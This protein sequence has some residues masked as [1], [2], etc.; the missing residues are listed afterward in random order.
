MVLTNPDNNT[1]LHRQVH[2]SLFF[3]NAMNFNQVRTYLSSTYSRF[4]FYQFPIFNFSNLNSFK[5]CCKKI[6]YFYKKI[7]CIYSSFSPFKIMH[8]VVIQVGEKNLKIQYDLDYKALKLIW[9]PT[10]I[11]QRHFGKVFILELLRCD[12]I[13]R[14][15]AKKTANFFLPFCS[16]TILLISQTNVLTISQWVTPMTKMLQFQVFS[17]SLVKP[18][19]R[20]GRQ[21]YLVG[22]F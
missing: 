1:Y 10:S 18:T 16:I 4:Y 19:I 9:F 7:L 22:N 2:T 17:F 3:A 20:V 8:F 11:I 14:C 5:Q 15:V 6:Y 21:C 12:D 13:V